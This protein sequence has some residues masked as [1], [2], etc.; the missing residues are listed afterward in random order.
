MKMKFISFI[1]LFLIISSTTKANI[2]W[3][4][5]FY[6]IS[7]N[8]NIFSLNDDEYQQCL[9]GKLSETDYKKAVEF[10]SSITQAMEDAADQCV[11]TIIGIRIK[12]GFT[13]MP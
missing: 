12:H 8:F 5:E 6:N 1:F 3:L 11:E 2:Y 4:Y 13:T 10:K 7:P 9:K